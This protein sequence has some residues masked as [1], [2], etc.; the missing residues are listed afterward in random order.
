MGLILGFFALNG[1]FKPKIEFKADLV[2]K[3]KVVN[4]LL[5]IYMVVEIEEI[6]AKSGV[7]K[8]L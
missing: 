3:T 5:R 4:V 6:E 7:G 1:V 8:P 2:F